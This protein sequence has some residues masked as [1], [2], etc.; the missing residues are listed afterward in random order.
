MWARAEKGCF[1]RGIVTTMDEDIHIKLENGKKIRHKRSHPE[2]V[3]ADAIPNVMEVEIGTRVLA[4]WYNRL[5]T[6]YPGT[7]VAIRRSFFDIRFDDGDKGCN[8]LREL[9]ILKQKELEEGKYHQVI[10]GVGGGGVCIGVVGVL[11]GIF[12][13]GVLLGPNKAL[14]RSVNLA[15]SLVYLHVKVTSGT[16]ISTTR[17]PATKR[18]QNSLFVRRV[19]PCI[20]TFH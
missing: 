16:C 20:Q 10:G 3:V 19:V 14:C 4:K 17:D 15:I 6:Y 13:G 11:L 12:D 5:D 18:I 1:Q 7:V 8:E 2:C 9:R